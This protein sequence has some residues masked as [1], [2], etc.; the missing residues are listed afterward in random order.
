MLLLGIGLNPDKDA[1]TY[2]GS[3]K[4]KVKALRDYIDKKLVA[5]VELDEHML[6]A[7]LST[8]GCRICTRD[9]Q[10]HMGEVMA[11]RKTEKGPIIRELF[12][13]I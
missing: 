3:T 6:G 9:M 1:S 13:R 8:D 5:K 4:D 10:K 11:S 12:E 7:K 2:R